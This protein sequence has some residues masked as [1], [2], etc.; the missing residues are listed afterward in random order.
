MS[1]NEESTPHGDSFIDG[2]THAGIKPLRGGLIVAVA[3]LVW[4]VAPVPDGLTLQAWRLFLIFISTIAIVIADAMPIFVAAIGALAISILTAVL[5]PS[6]AFSGFS[7]G[8]ILL[9]VVASLIARGVIRSGL[10]TRIAYLIITKLGKTTL[11]LGYS[12]VATDL[13]IAPA[14]PSNTARSGVLFPIVQ[15]LALGSHS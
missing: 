11:G 3:L 1:A 5:T 8:L 10:G 7:D 14:F 6:Q 9:I 2:L 13:L 15:S 4:F 12:M